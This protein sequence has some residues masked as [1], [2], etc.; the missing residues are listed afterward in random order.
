MFSGSSLSRVRIKT[1]NKNQNSITDTLLKFDK[2]NATPLRYAML[3]NDTA[4]AYYI[5]FSQLLEEATSIVEGG[6]LY[7][8]W[9]LLRQHTVHSLE[10][11]TP[12]S[13]KEQGE[14]RGGVLGGRG[15]V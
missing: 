6:I 10:L 5:R 12:E 3:R 9:R 4:S 1:K 13:E 15:G 8:H 2:K 7:A 11:A 14:G